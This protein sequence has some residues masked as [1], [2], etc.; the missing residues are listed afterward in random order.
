MTIKKSKQTK[1]KIDNYF[2][3]DSLPSLFS[4]SFRELDVKWNKIEGVNF[5]LVGRILICHLIIEHYLTVFIELEISRKLTLDKI[6]LTFSQKLKLIEDN[7]A[8]KET[9][10]IKGIEIVNMI[11]NKFSHNLKVVINNNDIKYLKSVVDKIRDKGS[12]ENENIEYSDIATIESFTSMICA[13]M[14]GYCTSTVHKLQ[15]LKKIADYL[16]EKTGRNK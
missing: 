12:N 9:G 11:R 13:F 3:H 15:E 14:A 10:I 8:L 16:N 4:D 7:E 1:E 5:E 6:R 2:T